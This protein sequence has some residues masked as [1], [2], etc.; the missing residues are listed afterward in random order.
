MMLG[1]LSHSVTH[2]GSQHGVEEE[3]AHLCSVVGVVY[4]TDWRL[5]DESVLEARQG[6]GSPSVQS[7]VLHDP[8]DKSTTTKLLALGLLNSPG[9]RPA[10]I[11]RSPAVS[12]QQHVQNLRWTCGFPLARRGKMCF[13]G[14]SGPA[15]SL[16][17]DTYT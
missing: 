8:A 6:R 14:S 10:R 3:T 4:C 1:E 12:V 16:P 17:P 11:S 15:F 2:T 5:T 7:C 13:V 9:A